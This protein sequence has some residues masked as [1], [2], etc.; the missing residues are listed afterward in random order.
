ML[1]TERVYC[2]GIHRDKRGYFVRKSEIIHGLRVPLDESYVLDLDRAIWLQ[3][4]WLTE[5][6]GISLN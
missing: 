2:V 1:L 6:T 3:C 4:H 5:L